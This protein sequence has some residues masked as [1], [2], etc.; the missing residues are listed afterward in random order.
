[1]IQMDMSKSKENKSIAE[2]ANII[3]F[4][5]DNVYVK[6]KNFR[7]LDDYTDLLTNLMKM[8]NYFIEKQKKNNL[9]NFVNVHFDFEKFSL[10]KLDT[11]FIKYLFKYLQDNFEDVVKVIYCRNISSIFKLA[12]TLFKPFIDK[13]T[14]DKLKFVKKNKQNEM[15]SFEEASQVDFEID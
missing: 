10:T 5:E 1:M 15:L 8:F 3:K 7:K 6:I 13:E 14:K 4:D 12:L 11:E 2:F 9:V